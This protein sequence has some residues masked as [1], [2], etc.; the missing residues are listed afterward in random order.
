MCERKVCIIC[1]KEKPISDFVVDGIYRR[2]KCYECNRKRRREQYAEKA[3]QRQINK[4]K[5]L[6]DSLGFTVTK[7]D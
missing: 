4:L 5:N 7:E 3:K 2:N 1:G 6:A